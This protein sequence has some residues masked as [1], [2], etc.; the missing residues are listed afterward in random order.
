MRNIFGLTTLAALQI[1]AADIQWNPLE[2]GVIPQGEARQ[3]LLQGRNLSAQPLQIDQV[4]SQNVGPK[5]FEFPKVVAPGASFQVRYTLDSKYQQGRFSHRILLVD[6]QG[7]NSIT[8]VNGEV[9]APLLFSQGII[10]IGYQPG[11][12]QTFILYA[13][14]LDR[15]ALH[16]ELSKDS[17]KEFSLK[18]TP[19]LLDVSDPSKVREGGGVPSLKLELTLKSLNRQAN[20]QSI[21][22][23]VDFVSQEFPNATPEILLIG[24]WK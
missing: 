8:E 14:S 2:L 6:K 5:D 3:V 20:R 19:V 10:D 15:K 7:Q 11:G 16:L 18:S 21:R 1:M 4:L 24:Y 12:M 9:R 17:Q 13:W 23:L 22:K